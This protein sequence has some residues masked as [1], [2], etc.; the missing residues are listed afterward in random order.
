MI[1]FR[2]KRNL[3]ES[4]TDVSIRFHAL[5]ALGAEASQSTGIKW[6]KLS[7]DINIQ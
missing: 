6:A 3:N 2:K 4:G 1:G 7:V 5:R